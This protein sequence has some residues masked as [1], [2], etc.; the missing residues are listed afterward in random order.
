MRTNIKMIKVTG[1]SSLLLAIITYFITIKSFLLNCK[2]L[3]IA[4]IADELIE[5][6]RKIGANIEPGNNIHLVLAKLQEQIKEPL[7]SIDTLLQQLNQQCRGR[8]NWPQLKDSIEK[9]LPSYN[10]DMLG[11]FLKKE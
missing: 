1:M 8:Y 3:E 9:G 10:P 4:T 6:K 2:M 7:M 5:N 11:S